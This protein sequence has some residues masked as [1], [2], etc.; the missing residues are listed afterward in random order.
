MEAAASQDIDVEMDEDLSEEKIP[1]WKFW[2][3]DNTDDL[4]DEMDSDSIVI[5]EENEFKEEDDAKKPFW[6]F[7]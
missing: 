5:P 1:F 7:W 3:K 4:I 6:K 2:K